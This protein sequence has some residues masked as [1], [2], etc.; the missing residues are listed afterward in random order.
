MMTQEAMKKVL[1]VGV[2]LTSE[3]DLHRL[4]DVVLSSVMELAN[5]DAGTLYLLDGDALRFKVMH[6]NSL[7]TH[8]GG[9]GRDPDLPP[10]PLR[11]ENVC[12]FA[13][14]EGR[15]VRVD[16][17]HASGEYDFSGPIRYDAITGYHTQSM[18]VV[19]MQAYSVFIA[20]S[21]SRS[22]IST[23]VESVHVGA[24]S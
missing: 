14:L 15:T 5:C 3:R 13:F 10:V 19:P 4:L 18:I 24:A 2:M 17:V 9:D 1:E 22:Y 16:D 8:A 12:A 11:R 6:T 20:L 7:G 23:P 21:K